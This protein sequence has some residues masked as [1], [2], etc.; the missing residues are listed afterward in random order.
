MDENLLIAEFIAIEIIPK[1]LPYRTHESYVAEDGSYQKLLT[2]KADA[3]ML[4]ISKYLDNEK[5]K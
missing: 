5:S 3:I 1:Y 4:E 2:E